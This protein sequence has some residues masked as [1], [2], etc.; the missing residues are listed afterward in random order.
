MGKWLIVT[1]L[2]VVIVITMVYTDTIPGARQPIGIIITTRI[3]PPFII[4]TIRPSFLREQNIQTIITTIV[5]P[6]QTDRGHL[7]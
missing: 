7:T 5:T 1:V 2:V 4:L 3:I 6:F